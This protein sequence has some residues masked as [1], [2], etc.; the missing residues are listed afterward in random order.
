MS[1]AAT[2]D[3]RYAGGILSYSA[4]TY[5]APYS[6][7][8]AYKLAPRTYAYGA[9]IPVSYTKDKDAYSLGILSPGVYAAF[10]TG[11]N[12]DYTNLIF[13]STPTA[14]NLHD[15]TGAIVLTNTLG[16][17]YFTVYQTGTFYISVEGSNYSSSEYSLVYTPNYSGVATIDIIGLKSVG[18]TLSATYTVTDENGALNIT[19]SYQWA[20]SSDGANWTNIS[21]A[22][23]SSYSIKAADAN[24]Y[25][26]VGFAYTDNDGF[27]ENFVSQSTTKIAP[28]TN[29]PTLSLAYPTN[30]TY[31]SI[32]SNIIFSFSENIQKGSGS[33]L[34][35]KA[36]GT[37]VQSFD[38]GSSTNLQLSGQ[39]LSIDPTADLEYSTSYKVEF[40]TNAITDLSGN[41][42]SQSSSYGF[43]TVSAPSQASPSQSAFPLTSSTLVNGMTHGFKWNLSENRTVDWSISYGFAGEYWNDP[44][45]VVL[46]IKAALHL[47]SYYSNIKFNYLGYFA[48][49]EVAATYGSE[50]NVSMDGANK[51]FSSNSAW[52]MGFFPDANNNNSQYQGAPGDIYLNLRSDA[53]YLSSYEPGSAGW[54]LI[55]HEL[56]HTL[57]L[58][59]PHDDG[60]TGRPT[61][62][63]IG[64]S[65][66]NIDWA[67][68]M[69]YNDTAAFNLISWD[70]ATPMLL[71]VLAL[72]YLYGK[73]ETTNSG[74]TVFELTETNYY[75]TIYDA[76]GTDEVNAKNATAAWTIY[77]PNIALTDLVSTKV[78]FAA[79]TSQLTGTPLTIDWLAG[80]IEN[81][82]GSNFDDYIL[83]NDFSNILNGGSGNDTLNGG[84]SADT[85][86]GGDGIDTAEF[87]ESSINYLIQ[88]RKNSSYAGYTYNYKVT[89]L[90]NTNNSDYLVGIESIKFADGTFTL[91]VIA[92]PDTTAPTVSSFSPTDE[93][94]AVAIA[95]N[96]VVTFSESI[97][98]GAGNIVLKTSD[99]TTVAT[100]AQ[101]SSNVAISGSTLTI[102]PTADLSYSTGYKVEFASGSV[103]DLAGNDYAG[104]TSYNFAT[105]AAPDTT[106]PTVSSFS[107]TD[108]ASAVAIA[109]N[110]VVTFSENI[111]RGAGNIVLKTSDGTTVATYAQASANVTISGSTLT[112]NPTADLSYSTGYKVEFASGSVQDLAGNDYAGTTSYNFATREPPAQGFQDLTLSTAFWRNGALIT[113][114]VMVL[115]TG[116]ALGN[117]LT[118][119][120]ARLD[121]SGH[122][123]FDVWTAGGPS[124][125]GINL[126]F[127]FPVLWSGAFQPQTLSGWSIEKSVANASGLFSVQEA[128]FGFSAP[129][130]APTLVG[131]V[132]QSGGSI[133]S[134]ANKLEVSW[135]PV[136][137]GVAGESRNASFGLHKGSV[138]G[139]G[140]AENLPID[141]YWLAFQR[142]TSDRGNSVSSSDAL[143]ALKIAVGLSPNPGSAPVTVAQF[144]AADVDGSGSVNSSDALNVLK[145][146]VGLSTAPA[147]QWLWFTDAT[148]KQVVTS[149]TMAWQQEIQI[150]LATTAS[151][152]VVGVLKGDVD[153]SWTPPPG[154]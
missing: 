78:G 120:S 138:A 45:S 105:G 31:A 47:F 129:L 3:E 113:T 115:G 15:P 20:S 17:L 28:D 6:T 145:M 41:V 25:L 147:A 38:V 93:A 121:P 117:G 55:L 73:N 48:N 70:P 119:K 109:S 111:Q 139:T 19:P 110:I 37:I 122:S 27:I 30:G 79:P 50:I 123:Q 24:K 7:S 26:R 44:D 88:Y 95:S 92:P 103:Q 87:P 8:T 83:G 77:L 102:N 59:H 80:D 126:D 39:L 72:Q 91:S 128:D 75:R 76:S 32:A 151:V 42:F 11:Y 49:P 5:D 82:T 90:T 51:F 43:T 10:T 114:S 104:T 1:W 68:V 40:G 101:A 153:G 97:Q 154:G 66:L 22:T 4:G 106:A 100:Y 131:R 61:F 58:K 84:A 12:W 74:D 2:V 46:Y 54:F 34:I 98:R 142:T 136:V 134:D 52:A 21:G 118:T 60:G 56:G 125:S 67:T 57:G 16:S 29:K 99:G 108:E 112:I 152:K 14:I 94:S 63:D 141:S 132:V 89:S 64:I 86:I 71:D 85:L 62:S 137:G 124:L 116:E 140:I 9:L 18:S 36:D 150:D 96:I 127:L 135:N 148:A 130:T 35:K 65:S 143:A 149:T 33:I 23:S 144:A 81:A 133:A 69:S 146:A 53:N 107:P 13:A